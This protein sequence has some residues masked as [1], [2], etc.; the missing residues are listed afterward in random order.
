MP[1]S[2][3]DAGRK[4]KRNPKLFS[5]HSFR[6]PDCPVISSESFR[7]RIRVFLRECAEI[8][9]YNIRSMPVWCT[10]LV[11]GNKAPSALSTPSKRLSSI[12]I[13]P[14]VITVDVAEEA[15]LKLEVTACFQ[16]S[17]STL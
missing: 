16:R 1:N 5:F 4:R 14:I 9:D 11:Q 17:Q 6:D 10:L 15:S 12:P 7:D 3:A 13:S 2:V 8:E